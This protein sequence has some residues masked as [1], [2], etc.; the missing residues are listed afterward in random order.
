MQ[1][2]AVLQMMLREVR[3]VAMLMGSHREFHRAVVVVQTGSHR[4]FHR[5]VVDLDLQS[6]LIS[7][8]F[9]LYTIQGYLVCVAPTV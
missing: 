7:E 5:A 6:R 9:E 3:E 1:S 2:Y 4:E 8:V